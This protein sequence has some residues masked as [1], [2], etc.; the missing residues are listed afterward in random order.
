MLCCVEIMQSWVI[1]G[2]ACNFWAQLH[3]LIMHCNSPWSCWCNLQHCVYLHGSLYPYTLQYRV[4][5]V[6]SCAP[7]ISLCLGESQVELQPLPACT[8]VVRMSRKYMYM[9]SEHDW[10]AWLAVPLNSKHTE[11]SFSPSSLCLQLVQVPRSPDLAI[12]V[13][14]TMTTEPCRLVIR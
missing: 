14:T 2:V 6:F 8:S 9:Y 13:S 11:G 10:W 12:F 7:Y 3:T 5:V 4:I 1:L